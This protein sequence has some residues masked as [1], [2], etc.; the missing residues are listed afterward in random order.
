M[1]PFMEKIKEFY[2]KHP[3]LSN[4]IMIV[5]TGLILLWLVFIFLGFW[6]HHGEVEIVPD[7][8]GL[9][10]KEAEA[11]LAEK[12]MEIII[13]DSI[14]NTDVA[15]G[16]VVES[17]PKAGAEVKAG[18]PVYVVL[19]AFSPKMVTITMPVTGVSSRQAMS[20][21]QSLGFNSVSIVRVPSDYADLVLDAKVGNQD[22]YV[23]ASLPVNANIVLKVGNGVRVQEV[24]VTDS[25]NGGEM[26]LLKNE[27]DLSSDYFD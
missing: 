23:G 12:D 14:Y 17:W 1:S 4:F 25:I 19:T 11:R 24:T 13:S 7:I 20:Y 10:F 3:V 21:L 16:T 15:P 6:T 26:D 22:I 9:S 5:F 8:N 27:D 2:K 18:R